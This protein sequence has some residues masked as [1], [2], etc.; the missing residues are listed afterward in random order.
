MCSKISGFPDGKINQIP[1]PVM[2]FNELLPQIGHLGELKLILYAF[3]FFDR[4]EE[5]MHYFTLC[6]LLDDK[7]FLKMM[8]MDEADERRVT[9]EALERSVQRGT[10]LHVLP[11]GA[12]TDEACYFLNTARGR[13]AAES[14]RRGEWTPGERLHHA[15][16]LAS[17]QPNIYRLYEENMGPLTPMIADTL[18]EAETTYPREWIEDAIR[19]AVGNNIRR[20]RYVEAILTSWKEKGRNEAYPRDAE[21]DRFRYIKGKYGKFVEH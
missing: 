2:F 7:V 14:L 19:I 16:K 17:E 5:H 9:E 21:E 13:A 8:G 12:Q 18:K 10:L 6:D 4:Q 3:W 20:W 11:T 1:V 15:A